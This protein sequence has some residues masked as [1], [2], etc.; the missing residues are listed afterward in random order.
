MILLRNK[1]DQCTDDLNMQSLSYPCTSLSIELIDERLK[2]FVR[3]HHVDLWKTI[4]YRKNKLK[5]IIYEKRLFD[6]LSSYK[7]T[8]E[9]VGI[10]IKS[11]IYIYI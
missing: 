9:Q 11:Y 6:K 1:L 3:Q 7:L 5:D 10:L 8:T 4:N 2:K